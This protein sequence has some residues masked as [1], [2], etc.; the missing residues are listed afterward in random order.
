MPVNAHPPFTETADESIAL[1]IAYDA[2]DSE[3]LTEEV[4]P[5]NTMGSVDAERSFS[6]RR[7]RPVSVRVKDIDRLQIH[8]SFVVNLLALWFESS[9]AHMRSPAIEELPFSRLSRVGEN[10]SEEEL[11]LTLT[12][13]PPT[14]ARRVQTMPRCVNAIRI[15]ASGGVGDNRL[16]T[17]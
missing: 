15:Q 3:T 6:I 9:S 8:G 5:E 10:R 14:T 16:S 17:P 7:S 2:S 11:R 12:R 13:P 4:T 1:G